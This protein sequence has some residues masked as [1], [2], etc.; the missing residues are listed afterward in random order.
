MAGFGTV[1]PR[2][3]PYRSV[4]ESAFESSTCAFHAVMGKQFSR[5][6]TAIFDSCRHSLAEVGSVHAPFLAFFE[7]AARPGN[8]LRGFQSQTFAYNIQIFGDKHEKSLP[9]W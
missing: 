2:N 3:V 1:F 5:V 6:K 9:V 7:R 4:P 8:L